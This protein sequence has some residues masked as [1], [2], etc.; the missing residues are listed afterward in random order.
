MNNVSIVY[1]TKTKHSEKIAKAIGDKLKQNVYN[2]TEDPKI[3]DLNLLFIVG[4][5]YGS[6]SSPDLMEFS[7]GLSV[8]K[9]EKVVLVTSSLSKAKGQ[10]SIRKI[11]EEKG[12]KVID[13]IMC[14]GSFLFF[15]LG[16]PKKQD[17]QET[18]DH[19]YDLAIK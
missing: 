14:K 13:E 2:I 15:G 19:A 16:N 1:A 3:K 10:E 5:I 8:E 12:I 4:G 9:V 11:L 7:R 6:E 18:A 17:M